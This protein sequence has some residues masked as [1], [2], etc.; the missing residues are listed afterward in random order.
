MAKID[1]ELESVLFRGVGD[2]ADDVA[3]AVHPGT[4]FDAVVGLFTG[5]EAEA[6]MMLGDQDDVSGAGRL[7]GAHPLVDIE[8]GGIENF[9]IGFAVAPFAVEKRVSAEVDEGADFQ[10]LPFDLL[11]RGFDVGEVLG[12]AGRCGEGQKAAGGEDAGETTNCGQVCGPFAKSNANRKFCERIWY[13]VG[14]LAW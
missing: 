2:E 5:P 3:L 11:R 7:D 12:A 13:L 14:R 6:V 9:R 4:A 8:L 10:F 1:A